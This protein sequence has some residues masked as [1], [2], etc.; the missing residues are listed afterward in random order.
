MIKKFEKHKPEL[1]PDSYVSV[2][3]LVIGKVKLGKNASVWPK[4]VLRGDIEKI[5]IG[6]NSNIQDGVLIHTNFNLP[7]VIGKN[8]TV[9]HGV[10]LHGCRVSDFC[11]IG[12]G[13]ILLDA[14]EVGEYAIIGSGALVPERKKLEGGGVYMGVPA[15]RMRDITPAE[16][17]F[18]EK[19][20]SEYIELAEEYRK[21]YEKA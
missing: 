14:S 11:L 4:A 19:R 9:G 2:D 8:V 1:D 13:A 3:A 10:I 16:R 12:M 18:I 6:E 5:V 17:N 15:K 20:A 7:T 21:G